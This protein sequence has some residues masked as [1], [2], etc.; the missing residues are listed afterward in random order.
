MRLTDLDPR[1][2][3]RNLFV[4]RCPHCQGVWLTCKNAA[5]T[6]QEQWDLFEEFIEVNHEQARSVIVPSKPEFAWE[7]KGTCFAD[8]TV[9]PSID[10]SESGH[11]HGFITSGE[12]R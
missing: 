10:A 6:R 4:F 1:W 5:M 9:T 3:H 11:W 12:I 7:V 8:Y 2:I